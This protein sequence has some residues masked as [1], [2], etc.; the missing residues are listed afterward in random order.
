MGTYT[1]AGNLIENCGQGIRV[2]LWEQEEES[3]FDMVLLQ[4]NIILDTGNS[5]NNACWEEPA[6]IDIGWDALQYADYI[7]ISGNVIMGS[8]GALFRTPD[9][10]KFKMDIHDNVIAQSKKSALIT[11][12]G[13]PGGFNWYM[14]ENAKE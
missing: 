6:A 14:M 9:S 8:T 1:A 5:M 7:E 3:A 2:A 12:C 4:N 11:E 10:S 13:V